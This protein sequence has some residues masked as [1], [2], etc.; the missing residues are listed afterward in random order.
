MSGLWAERDM[1]LA[2]TDQN[3]AHDAIFPGCK[4]SLS[5][6]PARV[7]QPEATFRPFSKSGHLPNEKARSP[8][9]RQLAVASQQRRP[10]SSYSAS[11]TASK[12]IAPY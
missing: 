7:K 10:K 12:D 9:N 4:L 2:M 11:K 6:D 8:I 5:G 1:R 3:D